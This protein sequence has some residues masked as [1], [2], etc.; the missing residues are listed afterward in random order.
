L[1]GGGKPTAAGAAAE[2]VR[3][4]FKGELVL[5]RQTGV[6]ELRYPR[7]KRAL[8][9]AVTVPVLLLQVTRARTR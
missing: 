3:A 9:L 1:G 4:D 5:S 8:K 6:P 2:R 7:W